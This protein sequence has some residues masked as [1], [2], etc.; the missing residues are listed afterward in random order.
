MAKVVDFLYSLPPTKVLLICPMWEAKPWFTRAL[1]LTNI[2]L[3]LPRVPNLFFPAM[4]GNEAPKKEPP[5][6]TLALWM[7]TLNKGKTSIPQ[8][9]KISPV[10][11]TI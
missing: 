5:W 8:I 2:A 1:R 7:D 10:D 4:E 9:L 6:E 3:Q 11:L